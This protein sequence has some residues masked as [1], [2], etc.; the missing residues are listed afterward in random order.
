VQIDRSNSF[1]KSKDS[2]IESNDINNSTSNSF[3]VLNQPTIEQ[4][5]NNSRYNQADV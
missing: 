5:T 1:N 4:K 2:K 3:N